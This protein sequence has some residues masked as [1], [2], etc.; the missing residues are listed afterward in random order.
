MLK[1]E[2]LA[3]K[4]TAHGV[5]AQIFLNALPTQPALVV[6]LTEFPGKAT[7]MDGAIDVPSVQAICR[8]DQLDNKSARDLA[9]QVDQFF[10]D[11]LAYPYDLGGSLV[12]AADRL[13]GGPGFFATD[14]ENRITYVCNYWIRLQR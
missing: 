4:L 11:E 5:T 12:L 8:G 9:H 1:L 7:E 13:G 3:A 10:M 14:E 2:A 6:C